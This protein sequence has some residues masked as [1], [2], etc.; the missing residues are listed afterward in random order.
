MFRHYFA[1]QTNS[2]E[3]FYMFVSLA[4]WLLSKL[5]KDLKQP[6]EYDDPNLTVN[7]ILEYSAQLV[8]ITYYSY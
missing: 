8:F 7:N 3:Q 6:Q 1:L 2:G 4:I 5:G